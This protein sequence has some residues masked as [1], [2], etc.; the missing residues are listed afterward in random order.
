MGSAIMVRRLKHLVVAIVV[1]AALSADAQGSRFAIRFHGLGTGQADRVK[2]SL[3]AVPAVNVGGDFTIEFWM[4]A[5]WSNNAGTVQSGANGDGWITG[6]IIVDR[7]VYGGGDY[8]DFG[9]AIG[10]VG[11]TCVLAF[12][13]HNGSWGHTIVGTRNVGDGA[14]HHVALVRQSNGAMRIHVDGALDASGAGPPGNLAYRVGRSTAWPDS[15]PFLVLGA[16]KHD[17]GPAYPSFRGDLDEFRIWSRA[18]TGGEI[19][20]VMVRVLPPA[21]RGGLAAWFRFEEGTGSAVTDSVAGAVGQL[22]WGVPGN[23]AWLSWASGSNAAPVRAPV[24]VLVL[25]PTSGPA[26][27]LSWFVPR[28]VRATLES[29]GL[30]GPGAVWTPWGSAT[31]L[32]AADTN[33]TIVVPA[34]AWTTRFFRVRAET[35]R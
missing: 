1:G 24:P 17:A 7:D 35:Y 30:V 25:A 28:N 33:V 29:A 13:A 32:L 27:R 4:R 16:E 20:N 22:R 8:G 2:I 9:A 11:A 18:L 34:G 26:W 10:R 6:N 19:S 21:E 23:G 14:W 3:A 5:A 12:G 31:N 15:D